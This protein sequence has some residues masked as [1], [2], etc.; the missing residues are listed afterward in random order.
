MKKILLPCMVLLMLLFLLQLKASAQY[1]FFDGLDWNKINTYSI[2][3]ADKTRVKQM[4]LKTAYEVSLFNGAPVLV[5]NA[6]QKEF[7]SVYN[8][9][10]AAYVELVDRFYSDTKN[11]GFPLLFT[12]RI[13][14]MSKNGAPADTI[15]K[16]RLAVISKLREQ[17]LWETY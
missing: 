14:D 5:I 17:G 12:L 10:F 9:D 11:L 15:D 1:R 2:P 8:K 3:S 4:F 13:V 16:Y 7:L 6:D